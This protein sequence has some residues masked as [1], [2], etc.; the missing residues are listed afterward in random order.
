MKCVNCSNELSA[1]ARY[2]TVCGAAQT[3]GAQTASWNSS[4]AL[5]LPTGRSL[6]KIIFLNLITLGIYSM[7]IYSRISSEINIV[8]SRYDGK[9]TMP[10]LAVYLLALITL[11]IYPFV[12]HHQFSNRVGSE[13]KRR[14]YS[15][16]FG[17]SDFW[18]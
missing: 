6:L 2:C 18:L 1:G 9:R 16:T 14:G 15:Y 10:F 13:L 4:P 12:W 3:T 8:A 7:V 11:G 17:A 5:Q